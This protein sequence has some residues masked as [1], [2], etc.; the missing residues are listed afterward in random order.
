MFTKSLWNNYQQAGQFPALSENTEADVAI[1][2]GGITGLT[3]ALLLA[4]AGK[5]VV[6]LESLLVGGGTTG[7]STGNLYF[8]IDQVFSALRSKYDTETVQKVAEARNTAVD[9][10]EALVRKNEIDCDLARVPWYLYSHDSENENKIEEELKVAQEAGLEMK[11]ISEIPD[12]PF[13]IRKAVVAGNQAQVN[14]LLYVYGLAQVAAKAGCSIYENTRVTE[15]K[16]IEDHYELHT[17]GGKV[18]AGNVVH[19]THTPKGIMIYHTLLGPYREYGVAAKLVDG[20]YPQGIFWGY[21]GKGQKISLRSYSRGDDNYIMAIGEPHKVGQAS[22]NKEHVNNLEDFLRKNFDVDRIT[23]R[24]G[25]QHYKPADLLP[26]IGETKS[27]SGEYVATGF[28]TDGLVYGTLAAMLIRDQITGTENK[29][30]S[31]FSANRHQPAKAAGKFLKENLNVAGQIIKDIPWKKDAEQFSEIKPGEGKILE[32]DG[33]KLAVYRDKA[34]KITIRS[35]KCTHM[36]CIVH[37]NNAEETWDCPCHGTR[38][39]PDGTV[40]EGPAFHPLQLI[41]N[42]GGDLESKPVE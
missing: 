22:S 12:L 42:S 28:S 9:F 26:Y 37:W 5:K 33:E 24:W 29:W 8:T 20:S 19:A 32:R 2:G 30:S 15:V 4:E 11:S 3:T 35:A 41:E 34:D 21:Y 7:H 31:L 39:S 6:V 23:N 14:P 10:I 1:I 16:Q 25:G 13:Q 40:L 36:G 18:K 27:G 17:T 38:F